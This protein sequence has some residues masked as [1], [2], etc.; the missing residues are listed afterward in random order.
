MKVPELVSGIFIGGFFF[1]ETNRTLVRGAK[2]SCTEAC[3][4]HDACVFALANLP[5]GVPIN[6]CSLIQ[7]EEA[8]RKSLSLPF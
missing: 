6:Y 1:R 4:E 7:R 5:L 8:F 3:F 2:A